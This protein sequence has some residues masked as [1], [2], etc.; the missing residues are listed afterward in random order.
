MS[1][2]VYSEVVFLAEKTNS[3]VPFSEAP[4]LNRSLDVLEGGGGNRWGRRQTGAAVPST[5][6]PYKAY[7]YS[8]DEDDLDDDHSDSFPASASASGMPP[9]PPPRSASYGLELRPASQGGVA[10]RRSL[11]DSRGSQDLVSSRDSLGMWRGSHGEAW[12]GSRASLGQNGRASPVMD[13]LDNLLMNQ[14][15]QH[16][17]VAIDTAS[18]AGSEGSSTCRATDHLQPPPAADQCPHH[19][20]H[21]YHSQQQQQQQQPRKKSHNLSRF[22]TAVRHLQRHVVEIDR[23]VFAVTGDVAGTRRELETL[24]EAVAALQADAD[25]ITTTLS[26]LTQEAITAQQKISFATQV[27]RFRPSLGCGL[28][29]AATNSK[30]PTLTPQAPFLPS[31]LLSY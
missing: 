9:P 10:L 19:H 18:D 25:T 12:Q 6:L 24:R 2:R 13:D 11:A 27:N 17:S 31:L 20:H 4:W 15:V 29:L 28:T 8:S 1:V 7:T 30:T 3:C 5:N 16:S 26:N 23:A 14:S 21:H 22:A